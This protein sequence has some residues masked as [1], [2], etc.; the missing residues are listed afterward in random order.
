MHSYQHN[1]KTFNHATRHLTRVERALYRDL[2]ELYYDTEQPLPSADFDRLARLVL[3]HSDDE[4]AALRVV[5]GEFFELT[6]DVYSHDYC[7]SVIEKYHTQTT[8]KAKAGKA[9]ALARQQKADARKQQ[10]LNRNEQVLNSVPTEA[11][12]NPTNKKPETINHKPLVPVA[13]ESKRKRFT[14]PTFQEV[15]DYCLERRNQV[16]P[17]RFI[18]FYSAKGWKVGNSPMKDW[19]ACVRTWESREATSQKTGTVIEHMTDTTWA[20]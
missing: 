14:P 2:I 3:A 18:D 20:N 5:L 1:I 6:G 8:L 9:S 11:Q 17:N 16:E 12:Q 19:K 7:D 10:R 15:Q 13:Q 4:K